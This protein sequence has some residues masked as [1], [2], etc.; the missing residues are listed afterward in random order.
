MI[1]GSYL[2][3]KFPMYTFIYFSPTGNVLHLAKLLATELKSP[4]ENLLPLEFTEPKQLERNEHLVL[5]YPIHG[6]NA[7]KTV[8]QFVKSLPRDLYECVSLIGVGC[9][10]GWANGAVSS[11]L[12]KSLGKKDYSIILDEILA[13][14]LTFI[15]S[16]PDDL[17]LKLIALSE[18]MIA[19][20]SLRIREKIASKRRSG[21]NLKL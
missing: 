1:P 8:K 12:R 6:F 11:E 16:F 7:P 18:S 21:S 3:F 14:P 10:T 20:L 2:Q 5:L 15:M 4:V 17:N 19:D 13:M 9:S